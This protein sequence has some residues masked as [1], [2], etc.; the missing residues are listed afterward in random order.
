MVWKFA[1]QAADDDGFGAFVGFGDQ[2]HVTFIGDF[3]RAAVFGEQH[4]TCFACGGDGDVEKLVH[5]IIAPL[6][7]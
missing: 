2:I 4:G 3:L 5:R 6:R 1:A 7:W